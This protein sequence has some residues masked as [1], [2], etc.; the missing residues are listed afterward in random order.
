MLSKHP[1]IGM[2]EEDAAD[3]SSDC[4]ADI[5]DWAEYICLPDAETALQ[6]TRISTYIAA[7]EEAY[8]ASTN[9]AMSDYVDHTN[10]LFGHCGGK[11]LSINN[12]F[13]VSETNNDADQ[14]GASDA[15]E[16]KAGTNPCDDACR[17]RVFGQAAED[18]D[19]P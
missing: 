6:A 18:T 11:P 13:E 1:D 3:A 17:P 15:D 16:V 12:L 2:D 4:R 9:R 8:T 7:C 19:Q 14:D 10:R 5:Y